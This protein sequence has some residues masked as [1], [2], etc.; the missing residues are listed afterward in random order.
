MKLPPLPND[1]EAPGNGDPDGR[2]GQDGRGGPESLMGLFERLLRQ[3]IDADPDFASIEK[4]LLERIRKAEALGPLAALKAEEAAPTGFFDKVEGDLFARIQNHREYEQPVNDII[5]GSVKPSGMELHRI[6]SRLD[7]RIRQASALEPWEKYLKADVHLPMGRWEALENKLFTR[8]ERHRKLD[9]VAPPSMWLGLGMYLRRPSVRIAAA[10]L[11]AVGALL[12]ALSGR[13]GLGQDPAPALETLVYQAQGATVGDLAAAFP[14]GRPAILGRT[15]IQSRDDG[16]MILVNQRG[17]VEMRNGS[18]LE[19]EEADRKK[20]GYRVGFAGHGRTARGNVT[21]FVNKRKGNEK[22]QVATPDYRIEVVGTYFRVHPDLGG[23]VSTSVLEGKVKIHSETYGEF[24]IVAGQSLVFDAA[25]GRYHVQDGGSSVRREDIETVPGVD[26]LSR[27][28]V[29][30]V[31][32]EQV[33][34]EV[35]IDNRYKGATPMVVL[36]PAGRH[37]VQL[38]LEGHAVVDTSVLV[39]VGGA[40]RLTVALPDLPDAPASVAEGP[41]P[42]ERGR[43]AK[44][45]KSHPK[46]AVKPAAPPTGISRAEEADLIYRKADAV[47][48]QDWQTAV[49]L[50]RQVLDNPAAKPLRKE[51]ASF[52]IARLRAEHE[53][54]KSQAKE[55]FLRYLAL[56]PDGAFSGESWLR[57]AELE[58]GRNQDKAIEYYLRAIEKLPRHPRLSEM[59]HRVGLLYLQNKRYDEA[60][61]MFRQ[62]LGNI[63]YANE[64]EKRKI[65][66]SLYRALVAK[67]D[68]KNADLIDKEYRPSEDSMGN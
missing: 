8:I 42:A 38:S 10:L 27:Y 34:A 49:A 68:R 66:Q 37:E 48:A 14:Q 25:S 20:V 28:G 3:D 59:Q 33:G 51:A 9:L 5:A 60:V 40:H 55:D 67:G 31:V 57:L 16:A 19:I 47:Q 7:E 29:V 65:Y 41:R 13:L 44:P 64:T 54:E 32:S 62:S 58:V 12:G 39:D 50:Y 21:F 17:F 23:R 45:A 36:L 1:G 26:E 18:H 22:Y 15:D 46:P 56:Y 43:H 53:R 61:A 2:G 52:S 24:E 35:R 30:T 4:A 6:E 11:L 63:L